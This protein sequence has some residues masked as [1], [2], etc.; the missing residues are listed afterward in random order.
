M[1]F[2]FL[3]SPLPPSHTL[4]YTPISMDLLSV[5]QIQVLSHICDF[6]AVSSIENDPGLSPP[7]FSVCPKVTIAVS[8]L[9]IVV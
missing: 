9:S 3:I 2:S 1:Y 5:P 6:R 7:S 8:Y 4:S